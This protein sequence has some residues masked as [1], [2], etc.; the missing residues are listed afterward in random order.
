MNRDIERALQGYQMVEPGDRVLCALSGGADSMAMTHWLHSQRERL[1]IQVEAAHFIHGLRPADGP[2]ERALVEAFCQSRDIPLTVEEGDTRAYCRQQGCGLEEGARA[3]RYGF[4]SRC[5]AQ[6]GCGKIATAHH[7]EDNA[8]TVLLQM[9]RGTGLRGLAGIPPVRG[10]FIRPL[11][12]V[13]RGQIEKYLAENHIP[14]AEDPSNQWD[15]YAR[16]RVRHKVLPLLEQIN[17]QAP[18]HIAALA[19]GVRQDLDFLEQA[20]QAFWQQHRQGAAMTVDAL[21]SAHPA[22]AGR[23]VQLAYEQAGGTAVLTRQQRQAV[24]DL[25]M[26]GPSARVDLPDNIV[27]QRQYGKLAW[28]QRQQQTPPEPKVLEP[29]KTVEF[30]RYQ[31]LLQ[32]NGR[33]GEE[34]GY[35]LAPPA[36]QLVVRARQPGDTILWH[37]HHRNIKKW[38]ID[39]KIPQ[40]ERAG[41]PLVCDEAGVLLVCRGGLLRDGAQGRQWELVVRERDDGIVR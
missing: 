5:A 6:R 37:G 16:N 40:T 22:V 4:L 34:R 21:Q 2:R 38:M 33:P 35:H 14:Y 18:R 20:A 24:L 31:L 8:E 7:M 1:G 12:L 3:L 32:P 26:A 15:G 17:G 11:L 41:I 9:C 13:T 39:Q 23:V 10:P 30:G 36:G 27:V 28:H 29:G 25:C 19:A